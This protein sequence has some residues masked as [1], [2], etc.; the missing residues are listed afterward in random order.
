MVHFILLCTCHI[1][2]GHLRFI[3]A[4]TS[5]FTFIYHLIFRRSKQ[6]HLSGDLFLPL[7]AL[8]IVCQQNNFPFLIL[9][10]IV[11]HFDFVFNCPCVRVHLRYL[12]I[13]EI[14]LTHWL[15]MLEW[16]ALRGVCRTHWRCRIISSHLPCIAHSGLISR[17]NS[18]IRSTFRFKCKLLMLHAFASV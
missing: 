4:R 13:F 5:H 18:F 11:S 17:G 3:L 9:P 1:W 7:Q 14:L 12:G 8:P 6:S 16:I 15:Q 10:S 2:S